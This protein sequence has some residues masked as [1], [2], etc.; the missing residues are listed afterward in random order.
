MDFQTLTLLMKKDGIDRTVQTSILL[1]LKTLLNSTF[2]NSLLKE[3]K[4]FSKEDHTLQ[5]VMGIM[6]SLDVYTNAIKNALILLKSIDQRIVHKYVTFQIFIILL[7]SFNCYSESL[8]DE[9]DLVYRVVD[10]HFVHVLAEIGKV[11]I[12]CSC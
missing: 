3:I 2:L 11:K 8:L 5:S 12:K 1:F 4:D 6:M 7:D 9:Y 10:V